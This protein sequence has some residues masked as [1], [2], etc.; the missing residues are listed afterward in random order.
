MVLEII[1]WIWIDLV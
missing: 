1:D